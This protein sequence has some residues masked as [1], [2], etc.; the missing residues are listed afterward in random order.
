[1]G[2]AAADP[3]VVGARRREGKVV[4]AAVV[5]GGPGGAG[6]Q[7]AG[8]VLQEDVRAAAGQV[9]EVDTDG[10]AGVRRERVVVVAGPG[11]GQLDVID[12]PALEVVEDAIDGVEIEPQQDGLSCEGGQVERGRSPGA[13]QRQLG[14]AGVAGDGR[15]RGSAV[16]ADLD[17]GH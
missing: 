6:G 4:D 9:L 3:D 8:G 7:H 11:R 17:R 12:V 1:R 2:R 10:I 5:V 15:E 13:A 14:A 16:V